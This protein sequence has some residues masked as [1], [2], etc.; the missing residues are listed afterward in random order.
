MAK[1]YKLGFKPINWLVLYPLI[2]G[3][4]QPLVGVGPLASN[5]ALKNHLCSLYI[6]DYDYEM[7]MLEE[8]RETI[9]KWLC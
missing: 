9:S 3:T 5:I 8:T 4:V 7:A 1:A 6:Y 2:S